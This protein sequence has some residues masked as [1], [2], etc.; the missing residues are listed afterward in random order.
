[1]G[2]FFVI[3][4]MLTVVSKKVSFKHDLV[5]LDELF[6]R[7]S[8]LP[9]LVTVT[10]VLIFFSYVGIPPLAGFLAK[11]FFLWSLYNQPGFLLLF[12]LVLFST[13]LTSVYYVRVIYLVFFFS[14]K[15]TN[16]IIPLKKGT[17]FILMWVFFGLI[18]LFFF[19]PFLL[20]F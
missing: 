19:Q 16:L 9:L 8:N 10:F 4:T 6:Q 2:L 7:S 3:H 20:V 11:F 18:F 12:L 1:M 14:N 15:P 17:A 5:Y 13:I